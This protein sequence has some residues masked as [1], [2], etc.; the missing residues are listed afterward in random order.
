ML[1]VIKTIGGLGAGVVLALGLLVALLDAWEWNECW[2]LSRQNS[3][4]HPVAVP[5]WC[6]PHGF[7][8]R[9]ATPSERDLNKGRPLEG[10][11][12]SDGL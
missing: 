2:R 9:A 12:E 7:T 4:G 8:A 11:E 5:E 3:A 10:K 1:N 6:E